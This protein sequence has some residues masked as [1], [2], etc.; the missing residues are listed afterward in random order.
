RITPR[1][2]IAAHEFKSKARH[3]FV[4]AKYD[5]DG[6]VSSTKS[7]GSADWRCVAGTEVLVSVPSN[8]VISSGEQAAVIPV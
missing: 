4:V 1:V 7:S 5:Q 2:A 6:R 8:S 3:D